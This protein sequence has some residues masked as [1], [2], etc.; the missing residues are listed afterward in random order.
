MCAGACMHAC[1]HACM[2]VCMFDIYLTLYFAKDRGTVERD[3]VFFWEG[4]GEG[5][6]FYFCFLD[7]VK[8]AE[9]V[10]TADVQEKR[11]KKNN[12]GKNKLV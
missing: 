8:Y 3:S 7:C 4:C 6:V 12:T 10:L 5:V 11:R 9:A 2:R 1:V